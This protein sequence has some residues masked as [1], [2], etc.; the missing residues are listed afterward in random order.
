MEV[1]ESSDIK[2]N[3][4]YQI[5]N[6]IISSW[7]LEDEIQLENDL[8][9]KIYKSDYVGQEIRWFNVIEEKYI[10]YMFFLYK[11][12]KVIGFKLW[13]VEEKQNNRFYVIASFLKTDMDMSF[14]DTLYIDDKYRQNNFGKLLFQKS[15]QYLKENLKWTLTVSVTSKVPLFHQ[16]MIEILNANPTIYQQ[17]GFIY[18]S[19]TF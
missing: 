11:N 7:D 4:L 3:I 16:K 8:S 9:M 10:N 2:N 14:T 18:F 12:E 13:N 6:L 5:E 1:K 17:G 15:L 19:F